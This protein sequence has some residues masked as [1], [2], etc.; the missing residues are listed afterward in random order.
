MNVASTLDKDG[1]LID[2]TQWSTE[3]AQTLA[4]NLDL[5]LEDWHLNVL[6]SVRA[7]YEQ[8]DHAPSTR[9]LIKF[10]SK[11]DESINNAILQQR[12]KTGLVARELCR[13]AGLP[14]PA[15]CL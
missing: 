6:Y 2:H 11:R 13:L 1:H 12:F 15:N 7:F 10:L 14:K 9:P 3:I 8:Y 4:E 5:Q